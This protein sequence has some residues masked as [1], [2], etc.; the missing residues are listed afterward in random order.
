MQDLSFL[1]R[2]VMSILQLSCCLARDIHMLACYEKVQIA[3]QSPIENLWV[4]QKKSLS[5]SFW[6]YF[7]PVIPLPGK[8]SRGVGSS[9]REKREE[10]VFLISQN[11]SVGLPQSPS[12][13][14]IYMDL[15]GSQRTSALPQSPRQWDTDRF[16]LLMVT[17]LLKIPPLQ[18]FLNLEEGCWDTFNYV[19]FHPG[20]SHLSCT[21]SSIHPLP[22][23]LCVWVL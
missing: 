11:W 2:V 13:V 8:Q 20:S 3:S 4:Q 23:P 5:G 12:M 14:R 15:L 21:C 19:I 9:I 1:M 6:R 10:R 18:R 7:C 22:T 17:T 16:R